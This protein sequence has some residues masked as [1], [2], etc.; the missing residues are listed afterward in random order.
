MKEQPDFFKVFTGASEIVA[1]STLKIQ[2]DL[3]ER[4][5][6]KSWSAVC[7]QIS[8]IVEPTLIITGTEDVAVLANNSLIL[9]KKIPNARLVQTKEAGHGLIIVPNFNSYNF[10][11][12]E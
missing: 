8:K 3:V 12:R 10:I 2:F 6:S 11:K 1:S 7:N 9:V 4:W 5:L